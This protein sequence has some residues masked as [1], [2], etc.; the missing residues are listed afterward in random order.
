VVSSIKVNIEQGYMQ[1]YFIYWTHLNLWGTTATMLL[2][3][4]HVTLYHFD[5]LDVD[6]SMTTSLRVYWAMWNQSIVFACIISG[7]YWIL[8]HK[9]P[10]DFNSVM[11][12]SLNVIVPCFDLFIVKHPPRYSQFFYVTFVGLSFG[13][14]TMVYQFSGGLDK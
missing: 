3:A 7:S 5:R 10:I 11:T 9:D 8:L 12:H 14:F 6:S 1:V 13:C 4:F 2:S